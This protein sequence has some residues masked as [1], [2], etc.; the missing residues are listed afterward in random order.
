VFPGDEQ[1]TRSVQGCCVQVSFE[2]G[3]EAVPALVPAQ[4]GAAFTAHDDG[5]AVMFSDAGQRQGAEG[6]RP[7]TFSPVAYAGGSFRPLDYFPG[8]MRRRRR[9]ECRHGDD[10]D[11]D[12]A[13]GQCKRIGSHETECGA[14]APYSSFTRGSSTPYTRSA[15]NFMTIT[16]TARRRNVACASGKSEVRTAWSTS[17]PRPGQLKTTSTT[18]CPPAASPMVTASWVMTG[19]SALRAACRYRMRRS[20]RPLARVISMKSSPYTSSIVL[21][22]MRRG[23]PR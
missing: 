9:G 19:S 12:D 16:R 22:I 18:T 20:V 21:R 15:S 4:P 7:P 10:Q 8:G 14:E 6:A 11:Q 13:A 1:G 23:V 5:S 2:R 17:R 3:V